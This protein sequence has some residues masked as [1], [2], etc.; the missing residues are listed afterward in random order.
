M[1]CRYRTGRKHACR[2]SLETLE[3]RLALDG[4]ALRITEFMA[5]NDETLLDAEGDSADWLEIYNTGGE[6]ADLSGMYLTDS[7]DELD[8]WAFPTGTSLAA[9]E[10]LV[11]FAS[12]KDTVLAGGE[13][14]TNFKLSAD[15]EFLALVDSDG[16]TILDEYAPEFPPQYE[17][18]SYGQTMQLNGESLV[19]VGGGATVNALVPT[20]G[21]L[22]DSWQL[23]GFDDSSWPFVGPTG[24]G[25]ENSPGDS[26]NYTAEIG[27]AIPSGTTDVYIRV[28][29]HLTSV[30]G[31]DRLTLRMMYDDG[32]VAYLN[33]AEVAEANA[34]SVIDWNSTAST[35]HDDVDGE[36]FQEFDVGAGIDELQEGWNVL[37][38]QGLNLNPSSSD[39]LFQPELVA[40]SADV[41]IGE[42]VGYFQ[43]ATPG[44]ANGEAVAGFLERPVF[45][46]PHGLYDTPQTVAIVAPDPQ[47]TIV[48]TTDGSTPTADAALV[49]TNG[50]LYTGPLT[51]SST[52][53]LRATAFRAD[54]EPSP[55]TASSYIFV[56]DVI[57]QSPLGQVPAGWPANAQVN[58]QEINYGM[59][60]EIISQYGEGAVEQSL[61]S[62]PSISITTD[63]DHLFDPQT[64]IYVNANYRGSEWERLSTVELINPDGSE[65]FVVDAGL[66]IRGGYSRNDYN[67]KHAFRLYFR[68][69]YGDAKLEYPLFGDEGVDEFDVLD[70]RTAQN[71]SW[72]SEGNAQNTFVREVFGRDLQGEMGYYYTRSTYVHLY[73]DGVYWGLYQTQERVEEHYAEAYM[74]GDEDDYDVVKSGLGDVGGTEVS[75]GNDIAWRQLF[76]YGQALAA[77]PTAN[78]DLYW[79][80]QGLNPDG[81]RNEALPVLLDV[82]NLIDYM[83]VIIYT[84]G[85][86]TGLS[87]FIGDNLANNW[88]GAYNREAAD[89]GFQFFI[90][91]NEHS[92]GADYPD[93]A[94]QYIDRTGPFNNGNQDNYYQFCPPYLHQDLLASPEYQQRFVDHVQELFLNG[95]AMT[96]GA[97]VARLMARVDEVEPAIIAEAARWGDSKVTT[98]YNK[99]SWQNEIDWLVNTYFRTRG[100]TV[101]G[102]LVA[103]GLYK[104]GPT[105]NQFGGEVLSGFELTMTGPAGTVYYTTDGVTDPREIGGGIDANAAVY[106][107]P[108]TITDTTTV[109]ARRYY[110]GALWSGLVEATFAVAIPGDYD[111]SGTV[112]EADYTVWKSAFGQTGSGLAADGNGDGVVD[113]ADYTV[114][115]DNRGATAA[116]TGSGATLVLASTETDGTAWGAEV[117]E[118]A[119]V[120]AEPIALV[121]AADVAAD[122]TVQVA[123]LE[124]RGL[125]ATRWGDDLRPSA[126]RRAA[127][128]LA[129]RV[130]AAPAAD[131]ALALLLCD[132]T[133]RAACRR[134]ERPTTIGADAAT[135]DGPDAVASDDAWDAAIGELVG[136]LPR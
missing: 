132:A 66:R 40:E 127:G 21:S 110:G 103:D 113:T 97:S 69:E 119:A 136:V 59:D 85:F 43:T 114:W 13:L 53:T 87:R 65:G 57:H 14:H 33:G 41:I 9:G 120:V 64:G 48:Y 34:P 92:L 47:A 99:T 105:F 38:I 115:R 101:Y 55:V 44:Y 52:T 1:G 30:D 130:V 75:E 133:Q 12:D 104:A 117:A 19:L 79:T 45:D 96:V 81:T 91:D 82:D 39:M 126:V 70:L 71:Y 131:E 63:L 93:H 73:V 51:I 122:Q 16:T 50:T 77:N 49:A 134:V 109:M 3:P 124:S 129:H 4:A 86:D 11:V 89:E 123:H 72:S 94:S 135:G 8:K 10:Y 78:A 22:G 118:P 5:S 58:G 102:Q 128:R 2:L 15:G 74:G 108:V 100:N 35:Y 84:G 61:L 17:D 111:G 90:H 62:L 32:F 107:R 29:F 27:T 95:G 18:I 42:H 37:A 20:D 116:S 46:A 25:Y 7:D 88:F 125:S 24:I 68:S 6:A 83:L 28:P 112:D 76:D 98:P 54:F 26:I 67:P 23:V 60:P 56:S 106:T 36:R 31:I 121:A 80:M